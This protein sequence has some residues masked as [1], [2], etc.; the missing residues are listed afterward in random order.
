[1]DTNL[2]DLDSILVKHWIRFEYDTS[3]SYGY[4]HPHHLYEIRN[5][6]HYKALASGDYHDYSRLVGTTG[7]LEHSTEKFTDLSTSFTPG[8]LSVNRISVSWHHIYKK[9]IVL[10]GVHRLAIIKKKKIDS[11]GLIPRK[12]ISIQGETP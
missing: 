4:E 1:M 12:W 8:L 5:S 11:N 7:Q 9:Y 10:D 6:I 3:D 2:I